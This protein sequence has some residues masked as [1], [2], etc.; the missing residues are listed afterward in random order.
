M[1][2]LMENHW[3]LKGISLLLALMLYMSTN[4]TEKNTVGNA[5]SSPFPTGDITETISDVAVTLNYD[6]DKYIVSGIPKYVKIK[7]EGPKNVITAVKTK[8]EFGVSADLR[9][10]SP[11]TYE[12]PLKY[13]GMENNL[14][15]TVQPAKIK[16]T[17]QSKAKKSFPVEV[18]YS[19]EN[20]MQGG[21]M[22]EKP[23]V[24]PNTV[25]VVG[26]EEELA[27]ISLVR[28]YVDL[29]G[30]NKTV[31]KE[32]EIVLYDEDGRRLDLQ[33]IPS[34]VS[35][36][37]S[38]PN[39]TATNNVEK[40]VPLAYVKKGSLSDGVVVKNI[41]LEPNEV[42]ISGPKEVLDNI[43]SLEGVEVDLS[44]ITESTTFDASVLLPKGV[45]K[46]NPSQ[47]KVT[48][49]VQKQEQTKHKTIDGISIQTNGL[50]DEF[51]LQFLSPQG[52]KVSVDVSG[53]AS[54][55]DKITAA[56]IKASIN[57]QNVASGTHDLPIQFSGPNNVSIEVKEK[58]AKVELVKKEKPDQEVQGKP[59]QQD[60]QKDKENDQNQGQD[61][62]QDQE[63]KAENKNDNEQEEG[64]NR[65]G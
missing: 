56:Q 37:I 3:F 9:G 42:T 22:V 38:V 8:R 20:Q 46:V 17:I 15:A 53:E 65:N 14:K 23:T 19:N 32:A 16:V 60:P 63:N 45:T 13:S 7:L 59:E 40:T 30:I 18:K 28:A 49:E 58:N 54:I 43:K 1:D 36:T 55:V 29:K 34:K 27:Q 4:L 64:A 51:T 21:S 10:Y 47:V 25:E 41:H 61:Q 12:V 50:S 48:V 11:G 6:E 44:K 52:G 57:L 62:G 26:T 35:V 33:T 24:K 5:N 2:K 31:T 39:Q